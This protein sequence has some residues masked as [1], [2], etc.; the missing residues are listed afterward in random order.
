MGRLGERCG[1]ARVKIGKAK[2][3]LCS[4]V[5]TLEGFFF[6]E[7]KGKPVRGT[8][9]TPSRS[10]PPPPPSLSREAMTVVT[11]S[12]A[13]VGVKNGKKT[14][15]LVLARTCGRERGLKYIQLDL[16]LVE[17]G[18]EVLVELLVHNSAG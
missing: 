7:T 10:S 3:K 1:R 18:S 6:L 13:V 11:T 16:I 2:N 9:L 14:R 5:G 17:R 8:H 12:S 4:V 15:Y